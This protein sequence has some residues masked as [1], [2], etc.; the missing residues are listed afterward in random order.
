MKEEKKGASLFF[1]SGAFLK[2]IQDHKWNAK[3]GWGGCERSVEQKKASRVDYC[4]RLLS[5]ALRQP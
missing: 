5:G 1:R 4:L 2:I 3:Q